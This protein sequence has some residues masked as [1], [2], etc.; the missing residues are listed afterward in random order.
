MRR[1]FNTE[2]HCDPEFHYMVRL[3]DRLERVRRQLIDR[4]KYFT[5]NRGR[6]YGKTTTLMA[7]AEYLREDYIVLAMDFQLLGSANFNSEQTFVTSFIE[8]L[9]DIFDEQDVLADKIDQ[10]TVQ[11]MIFLKNLEDRTLDKLF[12]CLSRMCRAAEQPV[13]LMIDEVDAASN[14]QVFLDFLAMLRGYYLKRKTMPIFHSV[15]LASVYDIKNL[16]L[17]L[18]PQEERQYNSPWNIAADFTVEM[19]F[20]PEDI[21]T[22]LREYE[23]DCHTGM[24]IDMISGLI[25][26]YTSGYPYLVSRICQIA[27]ERLAGTDEFPDKKSVWTRE[28]VVAAERMLR[29]QPNTLFDDMVKKLADFPELKNM[30]QDILFCGNIYPF[31]HDNYLINLG[32]TF[33]FIKERE[34]TVV[35]QNRIFE[36][37]LYDL[38]LSETVMDDALNR[39]VSVGRD[40]FVVNGM[41]QM[42]VVMEKFYQYFTE[43]YSGSDEKFVEKQG[44]KLFL[45]FLKPII[46]G[47]GNYYIEAQTRDARRT[48]VIVDYHGRQFIIE[49]KIWRGGEYNHRGERQLFEYLDYY[50]ADTGYLLSF[51]FN[52]NKTTGT[53]EIICGGKSI[54]EVVV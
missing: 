24:D 1:Y 49:L 4:G 8:C 32:V 50:K 36:T 48:D 33:G 26:E 7:L 17:K 29:R 14:Y 20:M 11:D 41:L 47:S 39:A 2:G 10:E 19:D 31:E 28:G 53:S 37:K 35:I 42:R 45:M 44:R 22:M 54:F 9:E 15:I 13:I 43:I 25:Y 6:Q 5:I 34:G 27:D 18:R 46:N 12:R 38:F 51:N 3:D 21:A 16:K 52:R 40:Q 30:I 23:G